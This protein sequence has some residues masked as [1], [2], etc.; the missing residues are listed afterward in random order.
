M[1]LNNVLITTKRSVCNNEEAKF[2]PCHNREQTIDLECKKQTYYVFTFCIFSLDSGIRYMQTAQLKS[3][4][5]WI[6]ILGVILFFSQHPNWQLNNNLRNYHAKRN[7]STDEFR[8]YNWLK[9]KGSMKNQL[10]KI[11]SSIIQIA[12]TW[13]FVI[14]YFSFSC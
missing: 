13:V 12:F 2:L 9:F 5:S 14:S 8:D 3:W 7:N 6:L 11:E 1:L 10:F 4:N